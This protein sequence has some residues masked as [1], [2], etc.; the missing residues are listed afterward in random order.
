MNLVEQ[1]RSGNVR[2]IARLMSLIEDGAGE[3]TAALRALYPFTGSAYLVGITGPPGS[4]KSTLADR[5]TEGFRRQGLT[6]GIVAVDPTSPFTGGAILAD[7]IRMQRHSLDPEVFI[8][9][10]ATRGQ[11]GGLAPAT[12]AVVDVLDAAGKAVILIETVGVGQDEVEIVRLAHTTLVIMVPGLGDE[13]QAIKAGILEIGDLFV[14]NKADREGADRTA[15]EL[16]M[17]L[18]LAAATGW[19]PPVLKTVAPEGV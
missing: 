10:M 12:H 15:A 8:R 2:A 5:L 14:V 6:V 19:K 11:L 18:G 4:G 9:S 3:A 7:R 17:M 1:V 16:Q 13:V